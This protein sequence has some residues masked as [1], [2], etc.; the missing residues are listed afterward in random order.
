MPQEKVEIVR[1]IYSEWGRGNFRAGTELFDPRTQLVLR[2]PLP[3]AGTY[4]GPEEIRG[5]MLGFLEA[6]DNAAIEGESF[7]AAGDSVVVGVHQHATG[8][9]SGIPVELRYFQVW[10][11]RGGTV[12][13]IESISERSDA[14][15]AAGLLE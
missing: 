14:L 5:Y 15:E 2:P 9:E 10:T 3:E 13:R 8:T 11:F 6:W 12:A 4:H 7:I 1:Q